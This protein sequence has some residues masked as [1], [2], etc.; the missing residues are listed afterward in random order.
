[1]SKTNSVN[2]GVPAGTE[3]PRQGDNRIRA[4]AAGVVETLQVDHYMGTPTGTAYDSD[5]AGKHSKVTL[6]EAQTIG[7]LAANTLARDS[8]GELWFVDGAGNQKQLTSGGKLNVL[9]ADGAVM[10]TGDQTIAGVKTFSSAPVLSAGANCSSQKLTSVADPSA[11][12]DA[13]TKKYVDNKVA[14]IGSL[15]GARVA[16]QERTSSNPYTAST[17][18]FVT[19]T[20]RSYR[21]IEVYVQF[22]GAGN[23]IR[24]GENYSYQD[25]ANH[26]AS[27]CVPI[28]K[29]DKWYVKDDD[30]DVKTIYW[31][32]VGG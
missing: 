29:G 25:D 7:D 26:G 8:A 9:D 13:A 4:L 11:A 28:R 15:F 19:A 30:G 3:N 32:P 2:T 16:M 12:Q 27:I 5:D 31:M 22:G 23:W 10:K 17:D 21:H 24:L 1:M 6:A 20:T 18:G 14:G